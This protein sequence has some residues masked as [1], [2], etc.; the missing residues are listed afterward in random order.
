M[1]NFTSHHRP[2]A[3]SQWLRSAGV[4]VALLLLGGCRP[5]LPTPRLPTATEAEPERVIVNYA[6]PMLRVLPTAAAFAP[7][8]AVAHGY[9]LLASEQPGLP[10]T[11]RPLGV[12]VQAPPSGF[13]ARAGALTWTGGRVV[14]APPPPAA[15]P[16]RVA[17]FLR[18]DR[19]AKR[20]DPLAVPLPVACSQLAERPPLLQSVGDRIYAVVRCPAEQRAIL[21][22]LDSEVQLIA[23]RVVE[24]A[25]PTEIFLHQPD[26]DY[27]LGGRQLLRLGPD[28]QALPTIGTVPPAGDDGSGQSRELVRSADLLL[29]VD[30]AAGRVIGMEPSGLA[31]RFEQHF[32]TSGRVVRL[33]AALAQPRRLLIVTA[34]R[35]EP[36]AAAAELFGTALPI[37]ARA[38]EAAV[39]LRLGVPFGGPARSDHELVPVA[40]ASGGGALLVFT[41]LGNSGPLVALRRLSF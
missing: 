33:R 7:A 29:V 24:G 4:L 8:P 19:D 9:V 2:A 38:G 22:T 40:A 14:E 3:T 20:A 25:L 12:T 17:N 18:Y 10:A 30:G 16:T 1:G 26:A 37:A 31:W 35:G 13:V 11:F 5:R 21:L 6:P 27:L 15:G 39:R 34:E 23:A 28:P 41:H 36:P 32:Y